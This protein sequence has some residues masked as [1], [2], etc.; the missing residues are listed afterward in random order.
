M[1]DEYTPPDNDSIPFTFTKKGYSAPNSTS[2]LFS[3]SSGKGFGT[4]QAAINVMQPYWYATHTYP[5]T[6]PK[7]VIGYG[8]GRVQIIKGRC[9][10]GGIRDLRA[11]VVGSEAPY[12]TED[13]PAFL[14]PLQKVNL[15]GIVNTH[16][17]VDLFG[18]IKIFQSGKEDLTAFIHSWEHRDLGM[19]IAGTHDPVDI[20]ASLF[21]RS[22][23]ELLLNAYLRAWHVRNLPASVRG[24]LILDLPAIIS[25]IPAGNLLAY[26]K[27]YP[28]DDLIA[29]MYGWQSLD[30]GAYINQIDSFDLQGII[31][32]GHLYR[33]LRARIFGF[34]SEDRDLGANI[35]SFHWRILGGILRATYLA[36]ITAYVF[37]ITPKNLNA[38]IHAWH[39]RFLQG[40][41]NGMDY[42]W[43]LTAEIIVGGGW[44]N[45]G[46]SVF[47]RR[48][49]N[50]QGNLIASAHPWEVKYLS[51]HIFGDN[52][53]FLNAYLNPFGY[54]GNLHAS[55][56]PKMI[57]LTTVV[58]ISTLVKSDL[59]A[60][61]N[62]PCL[63]TGYSYLMS[64]I[65]AKYK[66]DLYAFIRP[67][68]YDYKP[69]F[70]PA[71]V[72]FTDSYLEV[73]KLKLSIIVYPDEFFTEDKYKL[74]LNL[75]DAENLL[76]AYIRGTLRY[77]GITAYIK[78]EDIPKYTF[79]SVFKN[80]ERVI[81]KTYD[82]VL[83][84]FETVELA[85]KSA[86][87][88]YY[89]SSDGNYVWKQDR[90][91]KWVLDVRSILPADT[92][93][94]LKRRLHRATTVYD[95]RKFISVDE[96]IKFA[97]AYVT[98]YPQASLSASI[99]N[100]G[101]YIS[102][103]G[104]IS[105][106]YVRTSRGTLGSTITPIEDVVVLSKKGSISKI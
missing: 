63:K 59:S 15:G 82:G 30:L 46:A 54:S 55:I 39:E 90:F 88:D 103:G 98:E 42:P 91:E 105:P 26:L 23:E 78:G 10:F 73:D 50:N 74:V 76:T 75:L 102:L 6:C 12:E 17:P 34:G 65:Y 93:L 3:F 9:L 5:K 29:L 71:K 84:K 20:K 37:P 94:R 47:P 101:M 27:V 31:T 22:R 41:L 97:I 104:I 60:I 96:A 57:R 106:K 51:A 80:R 43:N 21:V 19:T 86:V 61:I 89:Y 38:R 2:M 33:D 35:H 13:L 69:S 100:R 48:G 56:H 28:Q 32:A 77:R 58:D 44:V 62:F 45:L 7:Y 8:L 72:G 1:A 52:A 16:I 79:D 81:H 4:L 40:V 66:G 14:N 99:F 92:S 36:D 68:V 87:K 67:I 24:W 85:F 11:T 25:P 53:G 70:L 95:L 83:T 49:V 18:I 64:S